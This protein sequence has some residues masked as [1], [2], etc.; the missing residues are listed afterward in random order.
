MVNL[1]I[2][3]FSLNFSRENL[4]KLLSLRSLRL[5]VSIPAQRAAS[6]VLGYS[7]LKEVLLLLEVHDFA[8][9]RERVLCAR[10]ELLEA[11]L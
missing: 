5:R 8:H 11:D 3:Q 7:R 10:V 6:L 2:A 4:G 9:P 1:K